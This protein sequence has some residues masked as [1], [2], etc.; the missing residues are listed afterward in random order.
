MI[1]S[2]D[3]KK[4]FDKVQ[5][6]F[7]IKS[8]LKVGLEEAY[9]N[10]IKAIY[11]KV[12]VNIILKSENLKDFLLNSES[13]QRHRAHLVLPENDYGFEY[14]FRSMSSYPKQIN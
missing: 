7:M 4:V 13:R 3:A 11:D 8:L 5:H 14:Y 2:V 1:M 9:L 10:V 6:S 12:T